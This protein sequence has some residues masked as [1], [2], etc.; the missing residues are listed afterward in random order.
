MSHSLV[1]WERFWYLLGRAKR[2][3][4]GRRK[5]SETS[6]PETVATA[7]AKYS[8]KKLNKTHEKTDKHLPVGFVFS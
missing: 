8:Y 7:V 5:P 2:Y 6:L 4:L 1:V 3:S